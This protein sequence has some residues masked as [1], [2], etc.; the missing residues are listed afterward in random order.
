MLLRLPG[1]QA[2][3]DSS[4]EIDEHGADRI[5]A[6]RALAVEFVGCFEGWS[7]VTIACEH[8][9]YWLLGE[10]ASVLGIED[11]TRLLGALAERWI[12]SC[13]EGAIVQLDGGDRREL[14]DKLDLAHVVLERE[15]SRKPLTLLGPPA[16]D[17]LCAQFDSA[18]ARRL[19]AHLREHVV[20]EFHAWARAQRALEQPILSLDAATIAA[21]RLEFERRC[22]E[23]AVLER[24]LDRL[25]QGG[26][27]DPEQLGAHRVVASEIALGAWLDDFREQLAHGWA[28]PT[29]IAERWCG[30]TPMR[31]G[32]LIAELG[33]KGSR[34]HSRAYLTKAR[35]HDRTVICHAYSP[36]AVGL[37]ERELRSRGHQRCAE[38]DLQASA[39]ER[40]AQPVSPGAMT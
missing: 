10:I 30:M 2:H 16:I 14:L 25:E 22:F 27:V 6:E 15:L 8:R 17:E 13:P 12:V 39:A 9:P 32:K 40:C 4:D 36:A 23:A 38:L 7:L 21:N 19:R 37:I 11:R 20:P 31:V 33:L 3:S 26:L 1:A 34:A 28:T 29:Q 18:V 5:E 35:G 24:L